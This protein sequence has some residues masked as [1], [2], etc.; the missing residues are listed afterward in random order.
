MENKPNA[1]TK[2]WILILLYLGLPT[3]IALAVGAILTA[4]LGNIDNSFL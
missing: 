4:D 3:V 2:G 1:N